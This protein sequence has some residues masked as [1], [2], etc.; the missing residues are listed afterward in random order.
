MMLRNHKS[1]ITNQKSAAFTLVE[2][3][4]VITIIGIL[5]ALLLPAVQAAREAARRMQCSKNHKEAAL[6]SHNYCSAKGALPQGVILGSS[7]LE[8]SGLTLLLPYLEQEGVGFD[9]KY[10][11]YDPQNWPATRIQI[12]AFQCPSDDAQGRCFGNNPANGQVFARS[13]LAL[14]FG[15]KGM[16]GSCTVSDL[17]NPKAPKLPTDGAFQF[18]QARMLDE[19]T[20][21][22]TNTAMLSEMLSGKVDKGAT[23]DMRGAWAYMYG[24]YYTHLDTPNSGVGDVEYPGGYCFTEP[25]MPCGTEQG[26][27]AY[28]WHNLARSKHPGGVNVAFVDGH[29]NFV[30]NGIHLNVWQAIG[31]RTDNST[32]GIEEY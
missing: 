28:L 5:I 25:E 19:F 2:L 8:I 3:L 14:C 21:G 31:S 7:S 29:V 22:T 9:L 30:P 17:S 27:N 1:E 4:V 23:I 18:E 10:R 15:T 13:N 32:L 11:P 16:C 24:Q 26:K 20:R 12:S 6:A